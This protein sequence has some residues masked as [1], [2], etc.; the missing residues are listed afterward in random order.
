MFNLMTAVRS[1]LR[2]LVTPPRNCLPSLDGRLAGDPHGR[3]LSQFGAICR[4]L[5]VQRPFCSSCLLSRR[6]WRRG[7]FLFFRAISSVASS[8]VSFAPREAF[9]LADLSWSAAGSGSGPSIILP[10]QPRSLVRVMGG[11]WF[12]SGCWCGCRFSVELP[13]RQCCV[14]GAWSLCLEEQFYLAAPILILIPVLL[15][16]GVTL[17]RYRPWLV[18]CVAVLPVI[19]AAQPLLQLQPPTSPH[20]AQRR[21]AFYPT[22]IPR[23][24]IGDWSAAGKSSR[25]GLARGLAWRWDWSPS[26]VLTIVGRKLWQEI[27]D[28]TNSALVFGSITWLLLSIPRI[29]ATLFGFRIIHIISRLSYGMYL[30]HMLIMSGSTKTYSVSSDTPACLR[31]S[32]TSRTRSP[33]QPSLRASR[34]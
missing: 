22:S 30:N 7:S 20:A 25:C 9:A 3:C 15:S 29:S 11:K 31:G 13:S 5:R 27:F 14:E 16:R 12:S 2:D 18:V 17:D 4:A 28:F 34:W 8:G 33:S 10:W 21:K 32:A 23:R 19:R 24:R 6:A 1:P 26:L